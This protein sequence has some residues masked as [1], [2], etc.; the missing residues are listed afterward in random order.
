MREV[1]T[2]NGNV[3]DGGHNAGRFFERIV[4]REAG[5]SE[6]GHLRLRG[7]NVSAPRVFYQAH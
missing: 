3:A 7:E 6:H 5:G 2:G 4:V 1:R